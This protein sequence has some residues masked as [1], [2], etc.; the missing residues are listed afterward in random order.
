MKKYNNSI[1]TTA[2][3]NVYDEVMQKS[4]VA[5]IQMF[6]PKLAYIVA[7]D[8]KFRPLLELIDKVI[9]K[10]ENEKNILNFKKFMESIVGFHKF[11]TTDN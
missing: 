8:K 2:L 3:R 9:E 4:T 1:S 5:D 10:I 7:K 6:R 11:Y